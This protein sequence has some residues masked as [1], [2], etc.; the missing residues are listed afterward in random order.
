MEFFECIHSRH[1]VR[2]YEKKDVPN[3]MIGKII[4]AGTQAPSAGNIQPWEFIVVKDE[5]IKED[6]SDAALR[7]VHVEKAPAVIV[8]C[9]NLEKSEDRYGHRGK[10]LYSIQDTAA[11]MQNMLLTAYD[12]GLGSCW[13][14]AFD[15]ERVKNI[16][17]I[18]ENLR[19]VSII[20]LGFPVSYEKPPKK[21]RIP[22]ERV[23][24]A[25]RYGEHF[26]WFERHGGEWLL[27]IK[28]LEKHVKNLKKKLD[29]K[30]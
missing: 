20:T 13:V 6:L 5:K 17:N 25:E 7:Q 8:V 18:P 22:F 27:K 26:P 15:E 12:L 28:P 29:R 1:S 24:W 16:L 4:Y 14:G 10:T 23:T 11:A 21:S 2:R 3:E 9:A 30:D 19:P